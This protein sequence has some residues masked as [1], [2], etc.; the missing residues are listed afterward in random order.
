MV[1]SISLSPC[2][3]KQPSLNLS[4]SNSKALFL[5]SHLHCCDVD[6]KEYNELR[7]AEKRG[8]FRLEASIA[9]CD[10]E[11]SIENVQG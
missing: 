11:Y 1:H 6:T 8:N 3:N 7:E 9:Q 2:T 4:L 5:Q 10:F